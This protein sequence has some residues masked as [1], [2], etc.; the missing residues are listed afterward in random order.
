[1]KGK[2]LKKAMGST[3]LATQRKKICSLGKGLS[4][5]TSLLLVVPFSAWSCVGEA[6]EVAASR[7]VVSSIRGSIAPSSMI[8]GEVMA[9]TL[10][11]ERGW[12]KIFEIKMKIDQSSRTY[13]VLGFGR[14]CRVV[15]DCLLLVENASGDKLVVS[16]V[17]KRAFVGATVA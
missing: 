7:A 14:M 11:A 15:R 2:I 5:S 8:S 4:S 17:Q 1:M 6:V 13:F 16:L 12:I 3:T 9:D 10:F